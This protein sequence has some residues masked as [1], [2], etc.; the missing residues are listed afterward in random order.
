MN[1]NNTLLH[2]MQGY[3]HGG[4]VAP[5][6]DPSATYAAMVANL[7]SYAE[8]REE[9]RQRELDREVQKSYY[10]NQQDDA[11]GR[12]GVQEREVAVVEAG[13]KRANYELAIKDFGILSRSMAY[14]E[15]F[16]MMNWGLEMVSLL[17]L[18][19]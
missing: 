19:M 13:D 12:L 11:A 4:W 8:N 5:A 3:R 10:K 16:R 6:V 18:M 9:S 1:K 15:W 2:K 14:K 17:W 7:A